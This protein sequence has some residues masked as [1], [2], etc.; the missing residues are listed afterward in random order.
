MLL[1]GKQTEPLTSGTIEKFEKAQQALLNIRQMAEGGELQDLEPEVVNFLT[2]LGQPISLDNKIATPQEVAHTAELLKK[3][4]EA[5]ADAAK[6]LE[7][8]L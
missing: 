3:I 5:Y 1:E 8:V 4:S 6:K 7:A 2:H